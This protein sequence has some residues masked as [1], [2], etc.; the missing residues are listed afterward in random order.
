MREIATVRTT[1]FN[2][3]RS[4]SVLTAAGTGWVAGNRHTRAPDRIADAGADGISD[5]RTLRQSR[6]HADAARR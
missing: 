6:R 5:S 4:R 3:F 2:V 1:G